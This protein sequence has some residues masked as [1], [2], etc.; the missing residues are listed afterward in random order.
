M[1]ALHFKEKINK[2]I[3]RDAIL[4]KA[5]SVVGLSFPITGIPKTFRK[6]CDF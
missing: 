1:H 6:I 3:I 4:E 5:A 2:V